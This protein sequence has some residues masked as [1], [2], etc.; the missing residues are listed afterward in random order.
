MDTRLSPHPSTVPPAARAV[1]LRKTYGCGDTAVHALDGI[2][3]ELGKG[4][5]TA[6]M[7][8]S[9]SGKSTLMHC[10]AGLD[11][12]TSGSAFIGDTDLADL[13]DK[14]ITA[15][16]RDR[17]GFIF[18]SFNLVPTLT[19]EENITLP[20]KVAGGGVDKQWFDEVAQRF[21]ITDRLAHR[22]A[23]LSGGQQ[24]R[25][26]CARA[27]VVKPEIIFGDEPTG[28]LDSNASHEVLAILR[29]AVDEMGQTVVIVTHDPTAAAWADRVLFLADGQLVNEL[30]DPTAEDILTVMTGFEK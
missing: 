19:A 25:V 9:G 17:L 20:G 26:A 29:S 27:I 11:A 2:S 30:R 22:P 23:E 12:P 6:I 1:D 15:L 5:F 10:M 16:R 18:Q 24:Q 28:N 4:E 3:V 8:P 7:G 21:S 13:R 14:D